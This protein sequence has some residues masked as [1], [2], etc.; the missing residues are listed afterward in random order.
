VLPQGW[1]FHALVDDC[2]A[3]IC[4][5][6]HPLRTRRRLDWNG[7]GRET[8]LVAPAGSLA[9][10]RYDELVA[11]FPRAPNACTISSRGRR[12]VVRMRLADRIDLAQRA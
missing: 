7:L 10:E 11:R 4:A 8:W 2:L 1:E 12:E 5:A 9:R 6:D 3:V